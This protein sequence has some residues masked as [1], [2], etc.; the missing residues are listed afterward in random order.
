MDAGQTVL[1]WMTQRPA[2]VVPVVGVSRVEH[3][4]QAWHAVNTSLGADAVTLLE[5]ARMASSR[6]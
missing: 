4:E 5:E 2:P 6:P 3:V 1:A